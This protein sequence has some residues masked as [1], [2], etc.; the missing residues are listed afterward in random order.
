[1]V[2]C[3]IV[4]VELDRSAEQ[5]LGLLILATANAIPPFDVHASARFASSSRAF[6]TTWSASAIVASSGFPL[7]SVCRRKRVGKPDVR[8][9]KLRIKG[10][11]LAKEL[12]RFDEP[13][14]RALGHPLLANL[15]GLPRSEV[16]CRD[17]VDPRP[18]RP[19]SAPP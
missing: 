7:Y 17:R 14:T 3:R 6:D 15:I 2:R 19:G 11:G 12:L 1:M 4:R 18:A 9:S 13:R 8:K 10:N 5:F 16:L